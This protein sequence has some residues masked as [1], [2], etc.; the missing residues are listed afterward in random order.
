[1]VRIIIILLLPSLWCK[2]EEVAAVER[3]KAMI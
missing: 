2:D 3:R 1:V